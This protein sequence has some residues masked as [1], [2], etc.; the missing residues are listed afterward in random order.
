MRNPEQILLLKMDHIGDALWS[1]PAIVAL[2]SAFPAAKIDMLCTP[3]LAEAFRRVAELTQVME[4]DTSAPLSERQMVLR[5]LR[6]QNYDVAIVLGPVDKVNHL[7]FLSGARERIGYFY[8]GNLLRSL[9]RRLFLTQGFPHPSDVAGKTG[10]PL[11]HE[12]A[13]MMSLVEKQ[14]A[15]L[16]PDPKLIFPITAE[17]KES[18]AAFL[19]K[20]LPEKRSFAALHL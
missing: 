17:E 18:A 19:H 3:Y 13:A 20:L 15:S 8:S 9:T 10:L 2:R 5:Q 4:Y 12:V 7:A 11:P 1:F 16:S 6:R 14:G